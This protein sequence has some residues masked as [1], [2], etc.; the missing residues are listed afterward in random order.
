MTAATDLSREAI[1]QLDPSGQLNDI[2]DLPEHLRDALWRVESANLSAAGLAGR[3]GRRGDG[4]LR[5]RGPAGAGGAG[6]SGFAA[7]RVRARL[8]AAAVDDA[9]R[10]RAVQQLFGRHGGDARGLRG[11]GGGRRA[12]DR[13]H[14][15]RTAG[16]GRTRR[17]RAGDPAPGRLPAPRGRRL[18]TR[19]RAR[20]GGAGRRRRVAAHRD[21][22]RR[23]PRRSARRGLGARRRRGLA[24]EA[25]CALAA[26]TR[27]RRSSVPD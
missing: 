24:R 25:A 1:A 16:A 21:R 10:D 9:R 22:R 20:G 23:R 5:D 8:R 17:R 14:D 4:R 18:R 11:R 6:R 15:R 26:T 2:L 13:L 12:A 7:D 19:G 27:S 3:A